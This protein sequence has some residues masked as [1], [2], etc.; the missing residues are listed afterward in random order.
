MIW[1]AQFLSY[2]Q[3]FAVLRFCGRVVSLVKERVSKATMA[4][5]GKSVIGTERFLFYFNQIA[6][7]RLGIGVG[8]IGIQGVRQAIA[9]YQGIRMLRAQNAFLECDYL[10]IFGH[11]FGVFV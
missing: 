3:H 2:A 10:A 7:H 8:V 9:I 5:H 4:A 11:G 6:E 1:P